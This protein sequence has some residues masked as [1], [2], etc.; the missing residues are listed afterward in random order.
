MKQRASGVI[1]SP[2][3]PAWYSQAVLCRWKIIAPENYNE[4]YIYIWYNGAKKVTYD[5]SH[6]F[7]DHLA[8]DQIIDGRKEKRARFCGKHGLFKT[9]TFGREVDVRFWASPT[10]RD[11]MSR[12]TSFKLLW[13][14]SKGG[15]MREYILT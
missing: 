6:C 2:R 13:F 5:L 12:R 14:A 7:S 4:I 1:R 15:L 3:L 9:R 11:D 10:R 8:I